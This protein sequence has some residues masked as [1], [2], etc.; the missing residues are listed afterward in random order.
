M[1]Y[2]NKIIPL[3]DDT[4]NMIHR[5]PTHII[6]WFEKELMEAWLN[7]FPL[8]ETS[9]QLGS[10]LITD[11]AWILTLNPWWRFVTNRP[12]L[13]PIPRNSS[14]SSVRLSNL[15]LSELS[16]CEMEVDLLEPVITER[17]I[18]VERPVECAM[19]GN[20]HRVKLL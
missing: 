7:I 1:F 8:T 10:L 13:P 9:S 19:L 2:R 12:A 15:P 5:D 17:K 18:L 14:N 20:I 4:I 16:L 3:G 6:G 11:V